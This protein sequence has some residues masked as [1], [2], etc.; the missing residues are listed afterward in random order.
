MLSSDSASSDA[1][2]DDCQILG[3]EATVTTV[4]SR[5]KISR[6]CPP[7]KRTFKQLDGRCLRPCALLARF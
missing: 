7:S 4:K 5:A 6:M 3:E 2:Q 1:G